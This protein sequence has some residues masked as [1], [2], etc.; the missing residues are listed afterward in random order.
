MATLLEL[1]IIERREIAEG[2]M[3]IRLGL[4]KNK[5]R[6]HPGQY[7]RL[8]VP[9]L[10]KEDPK[11]NRRDFSI[12]SSPTETGWLAIAYRQS[13]SGVKQTLL[14]SPLGTKVWVEGPFGLF[15]LPQNPRKPVVLVAGGI[16][17]TPFRSMICYVTRKKL[18]YRLTLLYAN[19]ARKNAAYLKE[20][21]EFQ[22]KNPR[23]VLKNRFGLF[24]QDFIRRSVKDLQD[25]LWYLCGPPPM[26]EALEK[27][28]PDLGVTQDRIVLEVFTG[29]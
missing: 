7:I 14:H 28:L 10:L 20:L 24:T 2:T 26:V 9:H 17:V 11:G 5:F 29:Y 8:T 18:T 25:P 3:E 22:R 6:F 21:G 16:G 15:T 27:M 13:E 12:A 23:F 4:E 1:P 19:W